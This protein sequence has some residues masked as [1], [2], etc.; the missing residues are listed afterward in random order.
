MKWIKI[1]DQLPPFNVPVLCVIKN[2][3]GCAHYSQAVFSRIDHD[4]DEGG[5]AWSDGQG[6]KCY[7]PQMIVYWQKLPDMVPGL[8][9]GYDLLKCQ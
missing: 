8:E 6:E 7:R 5:Y 4:N 9:P 1:K 2:N 3:C